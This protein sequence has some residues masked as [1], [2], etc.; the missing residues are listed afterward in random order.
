MCFNIDM[1]VSFCASKPKYHITGIYSGMNAKIP[2]LSD[3]QVKEINETRNLPEGY[4]VLTKENAG[5]MG[6]SV[7]VPSIT[8]TKGLPKAFPIEN[9]KSYTTL[10]DGYAVENRDGKT[11]LKKQ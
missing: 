11:Y 5:A 2:T 6:R 3:A 8:V 7:G 1:K 9:A 10:P 4:Y